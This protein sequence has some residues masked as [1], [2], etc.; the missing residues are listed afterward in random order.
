M[1]ASSS[2]LV[3]Q[4]LP[5]KG[6]QLAQL[7]VEDGTRLDLVDLEQAHEA[8]LRGRRRLRSADERDDLVDR[9][10]RREQ[11]GDDVQP[12]LRLAEPE[13]GAPQDHFDLVR[14]PVPDIWSRRR[15]R[16]TPSTSASMLTPKV[17]CSWVCLYRLF[18][19]TLAIASR[20]SLITSRCPVRPLVSSAMSAIPDSGF[21]DKLGDLRRQVVWVDLERASLTTRH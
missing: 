3:D 18:S 6:G 15:V 8:D 11:R 19:T 7:H 4:R 1:V 10:D 9:V 21:F 2:S 12:L 16:G 14:D 17:S 5:L 13:P 20:L